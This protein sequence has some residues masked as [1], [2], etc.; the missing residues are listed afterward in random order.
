MEQIT[1]RPKN[2]LVVGG[3]SGIGYAIAQELLDAGADSVILASRSLG[4]LDEAAKKLKHTSRQHVYTLAFDITVVKS[5]RDVLI[6]AQELL[7]RRAP[8]DGLVLSAGVNFDGSNWK[9]FNITE[10]DWDKVMNTNLKGVF[11]LM[12]EFANYLYENKTKGNI[13]VV[14]SISAHRDMLSVYQIT[15]HSISRI[16]NA[17]GK[18]LCERGIVLNCVEP[19]PIHTD[20]MQWLAKYTDGKRPGEPWNDASIRRLVRPEEIAKIVCFLMSPL[21]EV[22]SGDCIVAGGGTKSIFP[23]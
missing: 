13:C 12:R 19:G 22:M 9:G 5:H 16:V 23:N 3:G 8:L 21:G 6:Q 14:S 1:L 2:I 10:E 4:K 7:G 18:H 11:F 20:M 17:Y 15:K